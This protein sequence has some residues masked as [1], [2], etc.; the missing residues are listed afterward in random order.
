MEMLGR[1]L[2]PH[3]QRH[4][5]LTDFL[6]GFYYTWDKSNNRVTQAGQREVSI[7]RVMQAG[8]TCYL[9]FQMYALFALPAEALDMI[10]PILAT[11]LYLSGMGFG[12]EWGPDGSIIQF[13][14]VI[15]GAGENTGGKF[16]S[17]PTQKNVE[18]L[19][20][21]IGVLV[22]WTEIVLSLA[23]GVMVFLFP[24]KLPFLGSAIFSKV[25]CEK[26]LLD[27][28]AWMICAR[29][30]LAVFEAK[31]QLHMIL[32]GGQYA[33][34]TLMMGCIHLWGVLGEVC[35]VIDV[36][37]CTKYREA[38]VLEQLLNS[39]TRTRIFPIF[40]TTVPAFQIITAYACVKHYDVMEMT[41]LIAICL[42]M[43]DSTV[44]NLVLFIGSGKLYEKAGAYL[45]GRMIRARG[46]I[47]TK[48]VKSL[49]PLK[50]R[51]GSNFV[52]EL[53]ALRVQH[54]C[55]IKIIDLLLLL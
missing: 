20:N 28:C 8:N 36:P 27:A 12:Y 26:S 18:Q 53:T 37:F 21:V 41:H 33:I 43:L 30:G 55:S 15:V 14:N 17:V 51:F 2:I 6:H 11:L 39:C 25:T 13:M 16:K 35:D 9:A 54:F 38:H 50:I 32:V 23:T 44:F 19:I 31:Q 49:T 29:I 52:D 40:A 46:K 7:A 47:E 45:T 22:K 1:V 24:C 5:A 42:T 48:F 4:F 10:I 34:F 3:L